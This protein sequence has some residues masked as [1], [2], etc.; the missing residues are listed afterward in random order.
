MTTRCWHTECFGESLSWY[1]SPGRPTSHVVAACWLHWTPSI[2]RAPAV[3]LHRNRHVLLLWL[4]LSCRQG[5]IR[6][7]YLRT[8]GLFDSSWH[9]NTAGQETHFIAKEMWERGQDWGTHWLCPQPCKLEVAGVME[10]SHSPARQ[11]SQQLRGTKAA[12]LSQR[13]NSSAGWFMLHSFRLWIRPSQALPETT[14]LPGSFPLFC[15]LPSFKGFSRRNAFPSTNHGALNSSS[16]SACLEPNLRHPPPPAKCPWERQHQETWNHACSGPQSSQI[17][18]L[19]KGS[20][21][22]S[23]S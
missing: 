21:F 23:S 2:V 3:H 10:H 16:G 1:H 4:C 18:A 20:A 11:H 14:S 17:P 22:I 6:H 15:F 19:D 12:A 8:Y 7:H 13:K 5:F 9:G